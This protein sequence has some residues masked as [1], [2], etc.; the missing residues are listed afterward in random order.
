MLALPSEAVCHRPR[1]N[2]KSRVRR[3]YPAYDALTRLAARMGTRIVGRSAAKRT[4]APP[5]PA[6]GYSIEMKAKQGRGDC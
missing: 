1:S 3:R 4:P 6:R 5:L 2:A